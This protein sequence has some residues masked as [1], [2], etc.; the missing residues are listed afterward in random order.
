MVVRFLR[1]LGK[2]LGTLLV[3]FL[4]A[5]AVW[6]SAV[7]SADP[8]VERDLARPVPIEYVGKDP[9][10]KV[11]GNVPG[12]VNLTLMAPQSVWEELDNQADSVSAWVDLSNLGPGEFEVPVQVQ[13]R[14]SLV[15]LV[16]QNPEKLQIL[17]ESLVSQALPVTL[18][19][20][21]EPP[22]GYKAEDPQI[23]PSSVTIS[24]PVSQ[25]SKVKEARLLMNID[26]ATQT[27][28]QTLTIVPVDENSRTV[29]GIAVSPNSITVTQPVNLLGG[30]RNVIVKVV[31]EGNV[32][33][34]YRLTNYF[35]SPS[36]VIVFSSDPRLVNALPG[37]IE[38]QSLDLTNTDDDF[39]A[40]LELNLPAG[41]SAVTDSKV[42]VQVSIAAIESSMTISLP[43]EMI[44]LAPGLEGQ[45][46]PATVDVIIAGPVPVLNA[47]KPTDIR[48]KVDLAGYGV[49]VHQVIPEVDFLPNRVQ[50][51]SILPATVEVTVVNMATPTL[52][53]ATPATPTPSP[54]LTR[55]P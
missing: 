47:L 46:A 36:S 22:L 43:V 44:G 2:N 23:D 30:Y 45:V 42:L 33:S 14:Q 16:N 1:W 6:V 18:V 21:G 25:V 9:G 38:T 35:V 49:G 17:L 54:V 51:V 37:Y 34:G 53:S 32:A 28:T 50:K 3:A 12:E 26:G 20:S 41:V 13:I 55:N 4:L 31:T 19:I 48:V 7:L 27:I 24:G 8:N 52:P 39:E 10:L 11:M 29:T 5:L 15:R 40:L